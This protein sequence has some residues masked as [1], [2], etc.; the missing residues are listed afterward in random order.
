M[1]GGYD[2][3]RSSVLAVAPPSGIRGRRTCPPLD[4]ETGHY[5]VVYLLTGSHT[6]DAAVLYMDSDA[7]AAARQCARL[8]TPDNIWVGQAVE[9]VTVGAVIPQGMRDAQVPL[10]RHQGG[11]YERAY[12][13]LGRLGPGS[14]HDTSIVVL[15][16]S[17]V[18]LRPNAATW[19][20]R[21]YRLKEW[22]ELRSGKRGRDH[23]GL[24]VTW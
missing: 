12:R 17:E 6:R 2:P 18:V 13:V 22:V 3:A 15:A 10:L 7:V 19:K 1:S 11:P 24:R 9:V 21:H 20:G 14:Y 23:D 5:P 8:S 4:G 16:A